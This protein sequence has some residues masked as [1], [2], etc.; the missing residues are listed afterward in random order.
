MVAIEVLIVALLILFNGVLSGSE[1]AVISARKI[2]LQQL[3]VAGDS[4]AAAALRLQEDPNRFLSTV[5]FGITLVGILAGAFGGAT[6]AKEVTRRLEDFG[7]AS[8]AA[9]TLGV[10]LVV[11]V[12]TFFSLIIGE[13]V[14]KRIALAHPERL[15]RTAARPMRVLSTIGTPVVGL[16]SF[17]TDAVLRVVGL[18]TPS[19]Q[20]VSEE[21]LKMLLKQGADSGVIE[22]VEHEIA[23]AVFRLSDR[24][25]GDLATA[26]LDADW[27]DVSDPLAVSL[28]AITANPHQ[29]YPVC[30]GEPDR[31][32]GVVAVKDLFAMLANGEEVDIRRAA[33]PALFLPDALPAFAALDRFKKERA[34]FAIVVDEYGGTSG[35]LTWTDLVEAI[36]GEFPGDSAEEPEVVLRSDG[37][38]L[39]DGRML[40][41]ELRDELGAPLPLEGDF[42]TLAGFILD[43]LGRIPA[44][45]DSVT[46]GH[47]RF[48]VV[49]MDARRIDRVLITPI[50][51]P[52]E[53]PS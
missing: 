47:F 39:V 35:I 37:S 45:G 1:L 11:L 12:I 24:R 22:E 41:D 8:G 49:D 10:L 40:I 3:A 13:L 46:W 33:T 14:P 50:V 23:A 17:S 6:I 44:I 27:L 7:A 4:G 18:R 52:G 25:V 15:A 9:G 53:S 36:L 32:V 5:Q 20:A 38:R 30:D 26:R 2:R 29:R 43:R 21:E 31:V 28:A 42:Q 51:E 16:L 34:S 19:D 48:E